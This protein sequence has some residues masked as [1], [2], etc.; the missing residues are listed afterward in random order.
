[1]AL[2]AYTSLFDTSVTPWTTAGPLIL[3]ISVSLAQEGSADMGRH[4]ADEVTN[5]HRCTVLRRG[6][7]IARDLHAE[8]D[9]EMKK[10]V[11]VSLPPS[12]ENGEELIC[13]IAFESVKRR[14][15]RQGHIVLIRNK[16][17][18]PADVVLIASSSDHGSA[19]IETSSIDGETNLKLRSSPS[20]PKEVLEEL[21]KSASITEEDDD[22]DSD[23]SNEF[24]EDGHVR[25][26]SLS[27]AVKRIC[28]QSF[29][30]FPGG[31]GAAHNPS[32]AN[33]IARETPSKL[34]PRQRLESVKRGLSTKNF[35]ATSDIG[36]NQYITMLKTEPPNASINTFNG[37]LVLPPIKAGGES[38]E[39]PLSTE[40]MLLRGAVL[41]NT[42]WA[43]GIACYTG[44]DSK[45]VMNSFETPSKFSQLDKIVNALVLAILLVAGIIIAFL[46]TF[47]QVDTNKFFDEL[48]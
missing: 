33:Y 38:I 12:S 32:N 5:N 36:K 9:P 30:G 39:I 15:I 10:D 44:D 16:D 19:Y 43:I 48:W 34:T 7:E 31:I 21:R 8:R 37:T 2:G 6:D 41:R 25:K 20:I 17:Q 11:R 27:Q 26:E 18:V 1:M 22:N 3:M 29:L 35:F 23:E 46:A 4:R 13:N 14:D 28:C 45:L 40:N 42:R 47:N 24:D